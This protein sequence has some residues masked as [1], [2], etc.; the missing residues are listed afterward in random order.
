MARTDV[1]QGQTPERQPLERRQ[2]LNRTLLGALS[3]FGAALGAAS[4]STLWPERKPG[5]GN[6]I[7]VG[8]LTDVLRNLEQQEPAPL[9]F[10]EGKFYLLLNSG[11]EFGILALFQK[12]SHLGCRV[13]YC[14]SSELFECPCHSAAFNRAGEVLAGPA[15]AGMWRF[16]IEVDENQNLVVD[17]RTPQRQPPK[18]T[19]SLGQRPAGPHCVQDIVIP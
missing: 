9:Y 5:Y 3:V 7:A 12:C 14:P 19:D 8:K 13:P 16:P 11:E 1:H 6:R 4:L 17:T 15:R 10:P 2:F 18:G